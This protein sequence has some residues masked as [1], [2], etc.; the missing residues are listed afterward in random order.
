MS[1]RSKQNIK[2]VLL[3]GP[4]DTEKTSLARLCANDAGVNLFTINK[5]EIVS[6]NYGKSEQA[7]LAVFDSDVSCQC[8]SCCDELDA[9]APSRKEGGEELSVRIVATL[10]NLMDG[11]S[12]TED[13]LVIAATNRP[14]SI[15]PALR[16]PGRL[17]REIEIGVPFPSQRYDILLALLKEKEH[18]LLDSKIHHMAMTTHGFVGAN[19]ASLCNEAAFVYLSRSITKSD[20]HLGSVEC[21]Q[22]GGSLS[23]S[24]KDFKK[25]RIKVRPSA[26]RELL[27]TGG[28]R[29]SCCFWDESQFQRRTWKDRSP[30]DITLW[31]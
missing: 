15:E 12:R 22:I 24:F 26:M 10:L 13:L 29:S 25:A 4:P 27:A 5:P 8:F 2:G 3:H 1:S 23:V 28:H 6:Q 21:G 19:L 17:A 20:S 31:Q 30:L 14:D 18:R 7:L 9:I 11:I 16:G